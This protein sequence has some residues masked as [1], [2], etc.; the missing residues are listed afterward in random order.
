MEYRIERDSLGEVHV[1]ADVYYGAQTKRSL[2]NFAIGSELMPMEMIYALAVVKKAAAIVNRERGLIDEEKKDLICEVCDE[3]LAG[4]LDRHFPLSVWQTGSG[5]QTNMNVNEVISN[6]AIEKKGGVLGSKTPLHPNDEVNLSQS[7]NDVFPTAMH[8]A[9]VREIQTL[10]LPNLQTLR[11]GLDQKAKEFSRIVK[12]GRTHLMDATPL[13]L[14]QEFSGYVSQ[15]DHGIAAIER[16]LPHLYE[17]A[18]GG[19]AVG[20]GMNAP[21]GFSQ[22]AAEIIAD[23]T[24]ISFIS[25]PNKF[26]ALASNDTMAE[27]SGVLKRVACSLMKI[28]NDIR[29]MNSGPRCGIGEITLP[30]NE[31][32][33]SIMPGKVNPTQC[34]ALS[35]VVIQVMGNDTAIGFAASQGNFELNVYKPLIIYNILQSI[36][37]LADASLSFYQKCVVGIRANEKKIE[38]YLHHS[39]MLATALNREIGYDKASKIVQKAYQEGI[40]LKEAAMQLKALPEDHFDSIIASA[41]DPEKL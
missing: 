5:T 1:P 2:E 30:A 22:R 3:I 13:T 20:T 25:A 19:T 26:E 11:G 10:L 28:A 32:G 27:L 4:D 39:L 17:L 40:S 33:S 29:W 34:E 23:L 38:T 36:H 16:V 35:M 18:I 8:I 24:G 41:I 12:V 37:L 9:A 15:L 31:P 6:R 7:S 14:G 21:P